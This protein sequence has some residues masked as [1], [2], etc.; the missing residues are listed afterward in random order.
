MINYMK[1][2]NYRLIRK[3]SFHITSGVGFL[4]IFAA[5]IILYFYG[6]HESSFPYAN[7]S[8][9]YAN[10]IGNNIL[11]LIIAFLFNLALTGRDMSLIKQ[12]VSFGISKNT[13][14]WSKLIL[15]LS[16]FLVIC[17]V[18]ILLMIGLG[19]NIFVKEEQSVIHFLIASFNMLPIV[20]SGFFMI[21]AMKMMRV[22]QL[23]I[24][25]MLF[26]IFVFSGD[27]LRVMLSPFSRLHELYKYA[28]SAQFDD[29]LMNYMEQTV[30]F[31]YSYWITAIVISVICLLIGARKFTKQPID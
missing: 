15:T 27:L 21:H 3:K 10:V 18:G 7:S 8:F 26:F 14:F 19:E 2:E 24:I 28:P 23:F 22:S 12:S 13:I 16:Y 20:L 5:A 29:N 4:L 6:Q 30:Q 31:E 9:F 11:I 17:V 1:S 25:M